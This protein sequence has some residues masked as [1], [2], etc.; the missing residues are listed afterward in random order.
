MRDDG[1]T[2]ECTYDV[3]DEGAHMPELCGRTPAGTCANP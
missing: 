2:P 1:R 3:S